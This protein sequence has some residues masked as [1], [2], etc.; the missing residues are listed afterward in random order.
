MTLENQEDLKHQSNA[1]S[2][3]TFPVD[4]CY[5]FKSPV[6]SMVFQY[7]ARRLSSYI[8]Q[9]G[10]PEFVDT[11]QLRGAIILLKVIL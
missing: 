7:K 1:A 3:L 4:H 8:C 9:N 2:I 11:G 5:Q 10:A 6:V